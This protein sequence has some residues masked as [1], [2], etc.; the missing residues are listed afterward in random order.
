MT[1]GE[2][3]NHYGENHTPYVGGLVNHLPMG[4]LAIYKMTE[5]LDKVKSF[6]DSFLERVNVNQ[7]QIDYPNIHTIEETLGN[8]SLYE[9]CLYLIKE[10]VKNTD[11]DKYLKRMI[12]K[13]IRG[14][15]SGLFHTIIRVAYAIEGAAIDPLLNDEIERALAYYITAYRESKL[16]SRKI[17]GSI[18]KEE[19]DRLVFD[20]H[21]KDVLANHDTL[22]K[23][24]KA[25]YSEND[26]LEKG[27][28][29]DGDENEKINA[30][31]D[32]LIP[33]YYYSGNIV[34][35][36]C[37]TGLHAVIDMKD[38]FDNY[39]FVLDVLTT[40]II[41][42][43]LTLNYYDYNREIDEFSHTSWEAI[44]SIGSDQTDVHAVKLCHSAYE[45]HKR[46]EI[47]G[48]KDIAI[49]RIRH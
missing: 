10:E 35:L 22:G 39:S 47:K 30:L 12:N 5:D 42:H 18:I 27:F 37:I 21:L 41:T 20:N 11:R 4:Q 9:A 24:I 46:Y 1:I 40:S 15:S 26:F 33:T 2:M 49:K 34:A 19:M 31:L 17:P 25:L 8:R 32:L 3:I 16:F 44:I 13:Y 38:Y 14:L 7:V 28:V 48:L 43:L 23:K 45:L 36:H 29:I 6:T